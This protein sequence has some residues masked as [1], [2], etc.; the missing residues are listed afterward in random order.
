MPHKKLFRILFK[1]FL[2]NMGDMGGR[3]SEK[4]LD[5]GGSPLQPL[6]QF[7]RQIGNTASECTAQDAQ[8][9]A[10]PE[11]HVTRKSVHIV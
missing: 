3:L 10:A 8:P 2:K 5:G 9:K 1:I 4:F 6:P 11:T 7:S